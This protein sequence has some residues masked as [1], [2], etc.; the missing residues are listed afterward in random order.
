[1]Y[2]VFRLI[3]LIFIGL[4]GAILLGASFFAL[5]DNLHETSLGNNI[6]FSFL[7]SDYVIFA[8]SGLLLSSFLFFSFG[9]LEQINIKVKALDD[10][11]NGKSIYK[12]Y[13]KNNKRKVEND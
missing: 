6:S 11:Y 9:I 1:M 2:Q 4:M 5:A 3:S 13:L 12:N 10:I 7:Y 8:F